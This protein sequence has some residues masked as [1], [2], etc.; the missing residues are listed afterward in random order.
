MYVCMYVWTLVCKGKKRVQGFWTSPQLKKGKNRMCLWK[1]MMR[2]STILLATK[3]IYLLPTY[4]LQYHGKFNLSVLN[5]FILKIPCSPQKK[6]FQKLI[7]WK[8][9]SK[10]IHF[11][12]ETKLFIE[13]SIIFWKTIWLGLVWKVPR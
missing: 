8:A 7:Y 1:Q 2:S 4:Y 9:S 12:R 13:N 3:I 10:F 6:I 11:L 5:Y